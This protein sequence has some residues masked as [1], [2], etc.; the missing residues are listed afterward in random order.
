MK[1]DQLGYDMIIPNLPNVFPPLLNHHLGAM[2]DLVRCM[3]FFHNVYKHC[4]PVV[5][6]KQCFVCLSILNS[7]RHRLN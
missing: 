5:L 2:L 6:L 3:S 7:L 1:F 4:G